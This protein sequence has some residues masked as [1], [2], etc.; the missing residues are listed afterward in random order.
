MSIR[1]FTID[2]KNLIITAASTKV[3]AKNV[4]NPD[5]DENTPKVQVFDE[6]TG[7]NLWTV[8]VSILDEVN[9]A[10]DVARVTFSSD[11]EQ[12]FKFQEKLEFTNLRV[13]PWTNKKE[14]SG[15]VNLAF[16][17]DGIQT[18]PASKKVGTKSTTADYATT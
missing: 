3:N 9:E 1:E 5:A 14:A 17:A 16:K 2:Q 15:Q 4:F 6:K 8:E 18:K 12:V 10:M 13:L 7:M 11:V